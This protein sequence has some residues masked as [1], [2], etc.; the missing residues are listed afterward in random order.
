MQ[1]DSV[2]DWLVRLQGGDRSAAQPLWERYFARLVALAGS[3]M[4]L[5]RRGGVNDPEDVALSAFA[6]FF[7][8]ASAG[9]FPRLDDRDDLWSLLV[10]IVSNKALDH[11]TK[12]SRL[13][14]GGGFARADDFELAELICADPTPDFAAEVAE[15]CERMLAALP[16]ESHREVARRKMEGFTN[17]EIAVKIGRSN[18][19]VERKLKVIRLCWGGEETEGK[20]ASGR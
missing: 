14:R 18:K 5:N 12:Q 10:S 4:P 3:K 17:E 9:R 16:D 19:T 15:S 7:R 11:A 8:A 6:S 13:K 2:S 1:A 20:E